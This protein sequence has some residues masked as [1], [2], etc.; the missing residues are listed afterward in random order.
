[1]AEIPTSQNC[2]ACKGT[3]SYA[4]ESFIGVDGTRYPARSFSCNACHSTGIFSAPDTANIINQI[5]GR[6]G[7]CSKRPA[8]SR[9]Y[10]VWRMA[11][12][13][14]GADVTMPICAMSRVH[15]DPFKD[16]LDLLADAV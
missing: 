4:Y 6:K 15:G 1:M 10:Y 16:Q 7:L 11:R 13:H 8:S 14:G 12:F 5:S 3:G 2:T 9:A